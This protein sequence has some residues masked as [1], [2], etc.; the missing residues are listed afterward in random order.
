MKIRLARSWELGAGKKQL[1]STSYLLAPSPAKRRD[2]GVAL[3]SVIVIMLTMALIGASLF[4]LSASVND[5]SQRV[6]D[7]TKA[8]YLAEAGIAHAIHILRTQAGQVPKLVQGE[9]PVTLGDGTYAVSFDL[10]ESM[11]TSTG[12]VNG[13]KKTLQLQYNVF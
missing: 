7:E 6:L 13:T 8:R 9:E 1:A 4:E 3:I 5:S 10:Q 11:I 12:N 2:S